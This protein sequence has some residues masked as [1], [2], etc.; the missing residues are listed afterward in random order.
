MR[1]MANQAQVGGVIPMSRIKIPEPFIFDFE[2][3]FKVTST[4]TKEAKMAL[5]TM[6]SQDAKLWQRSQYIDIQEEC[7]T[8]DTW[9]TL[10]KELGS[11]F[12]PKTVEILAW[13]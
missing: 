3:Y 7:Y 6:Q 11:Q 13:R 4:T 5:A 8:I 9:H 12:F 10:K 1:A 2:Q